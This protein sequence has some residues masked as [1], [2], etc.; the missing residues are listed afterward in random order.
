M[1]VGRNV[2][3]KPQDA[4]RLEQ[5]EDRLDK[6]KDGWAENTVIVAVLAW[7]TIFG[8][9]VWTVIDFDYSWSP[10][11][12]LMPTGVLIA[13]S[14]AR[15]I[16]SRHKLRA[17]KGH[18][19]LTA[20]KFVINDETLNERKLELLDLVDV[21]LDCCV[22]S[23]QKYKVLDAYR[24]AALELIRLDG[25]PA[26]AVTDD[27]LEGFDGLCNDLRIIRDEVEGERERM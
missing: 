1:Q 7:V 13:V 9:L 2:I 22:T 26:N 11:Q 18:L 21:A 8:G 23:K 12:W 4:L 16:L 6:V 20:D 5:I 27:A 3:R 25:L 17:E 10:L 19:R 15:M 14:G 24:A